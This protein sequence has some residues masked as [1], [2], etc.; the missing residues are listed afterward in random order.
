MSALQPPPLSDAAKARVREELA[1]ALKTRALAYGPR[2]SWTGRVA[3]LLGATVG[4]ALLIA[5]AG[6]AAGAFA[7]ALLTSRV[8]SLS[9]LTAAGALAVVTVVRP[10]TSW[11]A[12]WAA[13]GA[14]LAAVLA[15]LVQRGAGLESTTPPWVCTV[16]HFGTELV[17]ALVALVVLR[18]FDP[19]RLRGALAGATVGV[20][21]LFLGELACER[22]LMH[23]LLFHLPVLVL[24]VVAVP[25]LATRLGRRSFAP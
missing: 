2:P 17:P 21:G 4:L 9:M 14:V 12:R 3:A 7:P 24:M 18:S 5:V 23:V 8:M 6:V 25:W 16:S 15:V 19:G 20:T 11:A 10:G 1:R 22:G 13:A